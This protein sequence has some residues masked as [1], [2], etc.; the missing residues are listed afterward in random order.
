MG[1]RDSERAG[2]ICQ[3]QHTHLLLATV[4][5]MLLDHDEQAATAA[6]T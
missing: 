5:R 2:A 1:H 3:K 4:M 6:G